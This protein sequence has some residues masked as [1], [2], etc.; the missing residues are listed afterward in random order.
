M[1]WVLNGKS[2]LIGRLEW[3]PRA[4]ER[5][6]KVGLNYTSRSFKGGL[7]CTQLNDLFYGYLTPA[8]T[9]AGQEMEGF[10]KT[11]KPAYYVKIA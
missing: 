3:L 5:M 11:D 8:A 9:D 10:M 2:L 7:S 1:V 4:F 6:P